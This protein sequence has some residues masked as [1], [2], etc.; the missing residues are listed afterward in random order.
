LSFFTDE[1]GEPRLPE[2]GLGCLVLP[3]A[4]LVVIVLLLWA[5]VPPVIHGLAI[6]LWAHWL[7]WVF[8]GLGVA[9]IVIALFGRRTLGVALA[10]IFFVV[11]I[12]SGLFGEAWK[13][14]SFLSLKNVQ[15]IQTEPDT[16]GFR[17]L[18]YEVAKT[19]AQNKITDSQVTYQNPEPLIDGNEAKWISALE[20]NNWSTYLFGEQPGD[21]IINTTADTTRET[22]DFAPGMGICCFDGRSIGWSAV[23]ERFWAD[24]SPRTYMTVLDGET[25]IVQPYLTYKLDWSNLLPVMVQQW[26]GDEVIRSDGSIEDLAASEAATKYPGARLYPEELADYFS[27]ANQYK[28][29][30]INALF[31]HQDMPDIPHL[32]NSSNQFPFLIPTDNGPEWY[33][34]VEPYGSSK[35]VYMAYY[36]SATDGTIQTYKFDQPLIGPDRAQTY[37]NSAFPTL[38]GVSFYEPR[39]FVKNG[40]FYWMESA[41]ASGTPDVQFTVLLDSYSEDVIRLDNKQAVERVVAGEDPRRVGTVVTASGSSSGAASGEST[42]GSETTLSDSDLARA[43]REAA[44]RLDKKGS[45]S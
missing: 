38:K 5:L 19:T 4:A 39:P 45:G 27:H 21:L 26:G 8:L 23:K 44:D 11:W 42:S 6:S 28:D 7:G 2:I 31:Y 41:A 20:P 16:T 10:V 12:V 13:Q 34:A 1:H 40:K 43:L 30:I 33:T 18:P 37:F 29:G 25:V 9:G 32:D 15:Q 3:L 36:V 24:Y 14:E 17:F 22:T 35:S